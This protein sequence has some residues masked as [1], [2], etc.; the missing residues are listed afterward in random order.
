[1]FLWVKTMHGD[2]SVFKCC[3]GIDGRV[4]MKLIY[5][6]I[7]AEEKGKVGKGGKVCFC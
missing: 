1:M 7:V 6:I 4:D 3:V 5:G 2:F